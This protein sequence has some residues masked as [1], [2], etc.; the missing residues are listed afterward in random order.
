MQAGPVFVVHITSEAG[1][2]RMKWRETSGVPLH[3][4]YAR[5][6]ERPPG[7]Y[8]FSDLGENEAL[9]FER[10]VNPIAAGSPEE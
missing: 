10:G 3:F 8:L 4:G 9:G 6:W 5:P 1:F 7:P 2:R